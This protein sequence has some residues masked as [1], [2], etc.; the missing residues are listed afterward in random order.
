M[1]RSRLRIRTP[2]ILIRPFLSWDLHPF[3]FP[4]P[5]AF[6]KTLVYQ[7][8]ALISLAQPHTRNS[9][10]SSSFQFSLHSCGSILR[11][12]V[13]YISPQTPVIMLPLSCGF[14]S[15][16][17]A[18]RPNAHLKPKSPFP[19]HTKCH[20]CGKEMGCGTVNDPMHGSDG[21]LSLH[22]TVLCSLS[23]LTAL[24][25]LRSAWLSSV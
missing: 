12:H 22:Y 18:K 3:S 7:P 20:R 10:V 23:L 25:V 1:L 13:M 19:V 9:L 17:R 21:L 6:L 24:F 5:S 8:T 16:Q 15:N 4:S 14:P 2:N 11:S